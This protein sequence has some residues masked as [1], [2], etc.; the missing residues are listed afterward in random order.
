MT[1]CDDEGCKQSLQVLG[2]TKKLYEGV[3]KAIDMLDE[4]TRCVSTLLFHKD[5]FEE[6]DET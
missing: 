5:V 6:E 2:M 3:S 1:K 4:R